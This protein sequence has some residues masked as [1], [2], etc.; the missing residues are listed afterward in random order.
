MIVLQSWRSEVQ[1]PW[2]CSAVVFDR[3]QLLEAAHLSWVMAISIL[4]ASSI[5]FSLF[6]DL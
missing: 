1:K 3:L 4:T 2:V 5:A 6:S